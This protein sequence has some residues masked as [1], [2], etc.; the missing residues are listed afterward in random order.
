[1]DAREQALADGPAANPAVPVR[2]P[3]GRWW[4]AVETYPWVNTQG[5]TR[6][7]VVASAGRPGRQ[8]TDPGESPGTAASRGQLPPVNRAVASSS[9]FR[10]I[11]MKFLGRVVQV[12][13][14]FLTA[15][16]TLIANVPTP[17]WGR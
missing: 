4:V 9:P 17:S 12:G 5:D 11:R 8:Q 10:D 13:L 7:G 14:V 2:T 15:T 3:S 16:S 1:G 6:A